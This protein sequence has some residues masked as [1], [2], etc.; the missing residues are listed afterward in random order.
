MSSVNSIRK[1]QRLSRNKKEIKNLRKWL[2]TG[3]YIYYCPCA[4]TRK[5]NFK[6]ESYFLITTKI[7][8]KSASA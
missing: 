7:N 1:S 5:N 4:P 3:I 2:D 6:R 8:C